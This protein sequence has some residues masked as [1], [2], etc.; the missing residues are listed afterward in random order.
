[1][2]FVDDLPGLQLRRTDTRLQDLEL[3]DLIQ[4]SSSLGLVDVDSV[5]SE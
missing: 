1:M 2:I 5:G 4:D 3:S